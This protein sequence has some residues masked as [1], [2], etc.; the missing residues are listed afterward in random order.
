MKIFLGYHIWNKAD[1]L[2]WLLEGIVE[3]FDPA[4]TELGFVFDHPL[5]GTDAAFDAMKHYWLNQR[6]FKFVPNRHESVETRPFK[7]TTI[8]TDKE[9]R[10]VGGH[11]LLLRHFLDHTDC[12]LMLAPQDDIRFRRPVQAELE[13]VCAQYGPRLGLIGSRDGWN[14]RNYS[15]LASSAWSP[16]NPRPVHYLEHG[17]YTERLFLNSGPVCYPRHVVQRVGLLDDEFIAWYIWEDYGL[18]CHQ[19]GF[20]NVILGLDCFHRCFGRMGRSS[21]YVKTNMVHDLDRF[22]A[23]HLAPRSS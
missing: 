4:T 19:A 2:C 5:D 21:L 11:N 8:K 17:Q 12:D 6:G 16:S 14:M 10:E 1:M 20:T 22:S 7:Y 18:R 9:V 15:D 3:N 13:A 23:K